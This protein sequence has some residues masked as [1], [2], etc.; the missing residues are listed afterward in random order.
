[1]IEFILACLI[2]MLESENHLVF[3]LWNRCQR[4]IKYLNTYCESCQPVVKD[5]R[6]KN[7]LLYMRRGYRCEVCKQIA[8]QVPHVVAIQT[9]EGWERRLDVDNL[10]CLCGRCHNKAHNRFGPRK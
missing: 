4:T 10:K 8:T 3:K 7:Q 2:F 6:E 5:E 9:D 1:M